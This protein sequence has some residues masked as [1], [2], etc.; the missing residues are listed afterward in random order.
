MRS[1]RGS[2]E[3]SVRRSTF[4]VVPH[5]VGSLKTKCLSS[6]EFVHHYDLQD[7]VIDNKVSILWSSDKYN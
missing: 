7:L 3:W 6:S 2:A 5:L 4:E 1:L